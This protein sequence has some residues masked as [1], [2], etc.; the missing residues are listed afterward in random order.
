MLWNPGCRLPWRLRCR[1]G[2]GIC[3]DG[4]TPAQIQLSPGQTYVVQYTLNVCA[5]SSSEETGAIFLKQ[6]PCGAFTDVLPL[7]FSLECLTH[8][9]RTL[10]H[11]SVLHPCANSGCVELSLVLDAK[12]ALCVEQATMDIAEL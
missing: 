7:Y 4:H 3:W 6:S 1:S 2:N 5:L 11:V 10:Q 9:P 12:T 8:G